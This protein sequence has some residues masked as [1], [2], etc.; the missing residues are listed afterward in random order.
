MGS[1]SFQ[2]NG[3]FVVAPGISI[4]SSGSQISMPATCRVVGTRSK[5][6]PSG[7]LEVI[8]SGTVPYSTPWFLDPWILA[9][10]ETVPYIRCWFNVYTAFWRTLPKSSMLLPPNWSCNCVLKRPFLLSDQLLQDGEEH[11]KINGFHDCGYTVALL[12]LWNGFLAQK[13]YCLEYHNGG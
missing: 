2:F 1:L 11:D 4:H 10:G 5:N 9:M 7:S 12:W 8:I 3:M 6:F 13:Q